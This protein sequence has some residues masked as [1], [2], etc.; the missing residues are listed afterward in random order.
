MPAKALAVFYSLVCY[1]SIG[2]HTCQRRAK[3]VYLVRWQG[4][5][6]LISV[7]IEKFIYGCYD[8]WHIN[9]NFNLPKSQDVTVRYRII[10]KS[11]RILESKGFIAVCS[12][13]PFIRFHM[14]VLPFPMPDKGENEGKT[15]AQRHRKERSKYENNFCGCGY[16]WRKN[17]YCQ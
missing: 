9:R 6:V 16:C 11:A 12:P 10:L 3:L 2:R 1:M 15:Q 13:Y 8:I 7:V 14:G 4:W 17:N 5:Q